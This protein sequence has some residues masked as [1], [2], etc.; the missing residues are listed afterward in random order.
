M[1][2]TGRGSRRRRAGPRPRALRRGRCLGL[3]PRQHA[4]PAAHQSLRSGRRPHPRL[5]RSGCSS[6]T[7]EEAQRVQ[8]DY[9]Q[10]YGTTLRGLMV[11]HGIAPDDFLEYV[12][13]IDHSPVEPDPALAAAIARAAGAEVHPHQR[14]AARMPRRSPSGS[15]S[16]TISRTSSTSSRRSSCRSPTARPMTASSRRPA[17]CPSRA[18][19]FEDLS[20]NL[21]VPRGARHDDGAG[22]AERGTREVLRRTGRSRAATRPCRLPSPTISADF[23]ATCSRRSVGQATPKA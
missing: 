17:S 10:R 4:L 20:R 13:D 5:C 22:R 1:T 21:E 15:A 12:H 3:R 7:P 23:S 6:S 19:M 14:L 2:A 18:A 11:E 8:K 16:P 9:Y